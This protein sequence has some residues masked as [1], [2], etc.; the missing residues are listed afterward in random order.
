VVLTTIVAVLITPNTMLIRSIRQGYGLLHK[1]VVEE[2]SRTSAP[3]DANK[4][5]Y[6]KPPI[7]KKLPQILFTL[8]LTSL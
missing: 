3:T 5:I 1:I 4:V 8:L 2:N 6:V 7:V